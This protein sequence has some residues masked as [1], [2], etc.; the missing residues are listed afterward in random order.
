[1]AIRGKMLSLRQVIYQ[2]MRF[3]NMVT[4]YTHVVLGIYIRQQC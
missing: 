4:V 2:M 1:M 3:W